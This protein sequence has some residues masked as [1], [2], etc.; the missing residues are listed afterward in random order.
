M[1]QKLVSTKSAVDGWAQTCN[2]LLLVQSVNVDDR[3]NRKANQNIT[4]I[5]QLLP[6]PF[7]CLFMA[8]LNIE[9]L[10]RLIFPTQTAN[11]QFSLPTGGSFHFSQNKNLD[12]S[13][14]RKLKLKILSLQGDATSFN[15]DFI[16]MHFDRRRSP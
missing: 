12:F 11:I 6:I 8:S 3:A 10:S 1:R 9:K 15:F 7:T 14:F 5:C 4:V 13:K 16:F 2:C